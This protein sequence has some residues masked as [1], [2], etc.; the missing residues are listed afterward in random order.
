MYT[1]LYYS[2]SSEL[3][4]KMGEKGTFLDK[5]K[6]LNYQRE[7]ST[8]L[9]EEGIRPELVEGGVSFNF[10]VCGTMYLDSEREMFISHRDSGELERFIHESNLP[11]ESENVLLRQESHSSVSSSLMVSM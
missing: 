11:F 8:R 6:M 7:I 9:M 5:E 1:Y 2:Y 10:G 3:L 4:R